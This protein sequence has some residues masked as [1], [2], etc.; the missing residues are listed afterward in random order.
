MNFS[1]FLG[2]KDELSKRKDSLIEEKAKVEDELKKIEE[3]L[4]EIR[5]DAYSESSVEE[6]SHQ[7]ANLQGNQQINTEEL[8]KEEKELIGIRQSKLKIIW[9]KENEL[10]VINKEIEN[11]YL[12]VKKS[13]EIALTS[14]GHNIF[15]IHGNLRLPSDH[16]Y[17]FDGDRHAQYVITREDYDTYE[18]KHQAFVNLMRIDLLRNRFCI[19]GVSGTDANFLAWINWV[20]DVLDKVEEDDLA[21]KKQAFFIYAGKEDLGRDMQQMLKNHFIQAVVLKDLFPEATDENQRVKA[22]LKYIQPNNTSR[23]DKLS[24]LWRNIDRGTWRNRNIDQ[25]RK[26]WRRNICPHGYCP[27]ICIMDIS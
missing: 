17:G 21:E 3:R 15:K 24:R 2:N 14:S 5:V 13:S 26:I 11:A 6:M 9:G 16:Q 12:V 8:Q 27:R 19:I 20:K 1:F 7:G 18:T 4:A 22:F 10:D 25:V 23:T